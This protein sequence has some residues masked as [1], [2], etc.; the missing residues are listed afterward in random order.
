M[1]AYE[2]ISLLSI[3]LGAAVMCVVV[4]GLYQH[5]VTLRYVHERLLNELARLPI[6]HVLMMLG[7]PLKTYTRKTSWEMIGRH[8]TACKNCKK[9][10]QCKRCLEQRQCIFD[11]NTC[12]NISSLAKLSAKGKQGGY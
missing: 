7:I 2:N 12:P 5:F 8:I 1:N 6:S 4:A 10:N 3:S 9:H 11:A